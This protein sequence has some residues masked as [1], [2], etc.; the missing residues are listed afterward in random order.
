VEFA[1]GDSP[2]S[3]GDAWTECL[4]G[5]MQERSTNRQGRIPARTR[6]DGIMGT[7]AGASIAAHPVAQ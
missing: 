1:G 4:H 2:K 3:E 6:A 5:R 7:L